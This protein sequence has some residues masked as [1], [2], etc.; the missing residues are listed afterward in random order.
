MQSHYNYVHSLLTQ[1]L[2]EQAF[3][4]DQGVSFLYTDTLGAYEREQLV[5][6]YLEW[7]E[8]KNSNANY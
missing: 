2:T 8:K 4:Q 7:K 6:F 1:V 3:L 5:Q